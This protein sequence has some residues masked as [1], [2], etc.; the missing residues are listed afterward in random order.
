MVVWQYHKKSTLKKKLMYLSQQ[1][2]FHLF[3]H[4]KTMFSWWAFTGTFLF[5]EASSGGAL[6]VRELEKE[7]REIQW[8]EGR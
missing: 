3:N 5:S 2:I 4:F 1:I 6:L 8:E 7:E